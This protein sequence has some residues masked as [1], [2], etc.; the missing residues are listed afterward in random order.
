MTQ[1]EKS[2]K[3]T[4]RKKQFFQYVAHRQRDPS[5]QRAVKYQA[6]SCC[7]FPPKVKKVRFHIFLQVGGFHQR[8]LNASLPDG[9]N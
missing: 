8:Y 3:K 2:R 1:L 6:V 5:G 4:G 7:L 9:K